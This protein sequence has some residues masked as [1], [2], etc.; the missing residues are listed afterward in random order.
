[1]SDLQDSLRR[2]SNLSRLETILDLARR[3]NSLARWPTSD[4]EWFARL[5]S[6]FAVGPEECRLSAALNDRPAAAPPIAALIDELRKSAGTP[7]ELH[8]EFAGIVALLR[9]LLSGDA[10]LEAA[11]VTRV[12]Q[13]AEMLRRRLLQENSVMRRSK[14][15]ERVAY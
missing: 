14:T 7:E 3:S 13:I 1:M 15:G 2:A 11:D 10:D 12:Q 8:R 6:P 9:K 5:L 4:R